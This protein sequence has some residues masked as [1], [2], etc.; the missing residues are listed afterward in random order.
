MFKSFERFTF[1]SCIGPAL[2]ACLW[3][4]EE[5]PRAVV[6]LVH[7]MAEHIDRYDRA[8][9][10]LCDAG[11]AVV[12]HTHL[13]HGPR[14]E[15]H[16]YFGPKDG[17]DN[18][19]RDV[20]ALR[21]QTE[22][23]FPGL[24][25]FIFGHSMGSF[26]VRCYLMEHAEGLTGAVIC[27]TGY[28]A[29]ALTKFALL[30]SSAVCALGGAAKPSPLINAIGFSSSNAAFKPN[31]TDSDWLTRDNDI[32]D[33]FV[34]DPD[35]GFIFTGS[36]YRDMFVGLNRLNDMDKVNSMPKDLP[37]LFISGGKDPVGQQ[38]EGVKKVAE[39]FKGAGMKDVTMILYPE[40]RHEILNELDRDQV[41][42]DLAAWLVSKL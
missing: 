31:R 25:Y 19:I 21:L 22:A 16:G 6:Q 13:G 28:Y 40:D 14:A 9:R 1:P 18:L 35:C 33:A 5:K 34:A 15:L 8:A 41:D 20:H 26:V 27:G 39:Q 36:G 11:F 2:D 3:L 29:P 12:G 10:A 17:W 24:P 23:R 32:V 7:G 37:V 4:P 30:L 38:G 42:H